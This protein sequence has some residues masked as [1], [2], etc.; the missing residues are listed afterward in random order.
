M[1]VRAGASTFT[2][3]L[4]AGL[5]SSARN[6]SAFR[7]T[8]SHSRHRTAPRAFRAGRRTFARRPSAMPGSQPRCLGDDAYPR[9]TA[10]SVQRLR[11]SVR[12][13]AAAIS[14]C[15]TRRRTLAGG[16][17]QRSPRTS[18]RNA[19]TVPCATF[20]P[21]AASSVRACTSQTAKVPAALDVTHG[22][23]LRR[24]TRL[25]SWSISSRCARCS[26]CLQN[27][28][29]SLGSVACHGAALR[30]TEPPLIS[31]CCR[32]QNASLSSAR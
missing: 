26:I 6:R 23:R 12:A 10:R 3:D 15:S 1:T 24:R 27:R 4:D 13:A 30:R 19:K 11:T 2:P 5:N 14:S 20:A 8:S 29:R 17:G 22:V 28:R 9:M 31:Q 32:R 7:V 18:S 21:R 25:R 16:T